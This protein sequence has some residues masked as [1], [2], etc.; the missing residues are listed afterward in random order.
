M[1]NTHIRV[2]TRGKACIQPPLGNGLLVNIK[3]S[4]HQTSP[5]WLEFLRRSIPKSRDSGSFCVKD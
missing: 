4:L 1:E 2:L 3:F 5:S